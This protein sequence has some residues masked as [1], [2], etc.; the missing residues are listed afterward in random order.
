M[1]RC[2]RAWACVG[3]GDRETARAAEVW[4]DSPFPLSCSF[5][6][7]C[8]SEFDPVDAQPYAQIGVEMLGAHLAQSEAAMVRCR[9]EQAAS[10]RDTAREKAAMLQ[11][12]LSK[13]GAAHSQTKAELAKVSEANEV[14]EG[15][16]A[17]A[18][19]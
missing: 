13:I 9:E 16:L 6:R 3:A 4:R 11:A 17:A 1:D 12:T 19:A 14:L 10:E 5:A 7:S 15:E 18:K 8:V 2:G